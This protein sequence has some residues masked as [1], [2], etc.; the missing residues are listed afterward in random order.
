MAT[1]RDRTRFFT[2]R[3]VTTMVVALMAA[4]VLTPGVVGAVDAFTN[5]AVQDP[6]TGVKAQVDNARRLL[7]T[8]PVSATGSVIARATPL[9]DL[10]RFTSKTSGAGCLTV[11]VP[12]SG[13]ALV[14]R[15]LNIDITWA[16]TPSSVGLSIDPASAPCTTPYVQ[17]AHFTD[18]GLIPVDFGEGLAI[19]SGK[20]LHLTVYNGTG[21]QVAAY[22]YQVPASAI[23]AA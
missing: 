23:P 22:G 15:T 20:S 11:A 19:P 17:Q 3:Q 5:V 8:G 10:R 13:K 2:G 9:S 1:N 4:V 18:R 12:A 14:L 16:E 21:A 7:V 6:V